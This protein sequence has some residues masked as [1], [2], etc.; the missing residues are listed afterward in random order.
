MLMSNAFALSGDNRRSRYRSGT[1]S[2]MR[3][4]SATLPRGEFAMLHS[5]YWRD[6]NSGLFEM[7]ISPRSAPPEPLAP[8]PVPPVPVNAEL[9]Y[10]PPKTVRQE[11]DRRR[12]SSTGSLRLEGP[13]ITVDSASTLTASAELDSAVHRISP[14]TEAMVPLPPTPQV[15][16]PVLKTQPIEEKQILNSEPG[17]SQDSSTKHESVAYSEAIRSPSLSVS[18]VLDYYSFP[19]SPDLVLGLDRNFRPA[20]SPISEESTS[21]L[22][23]ASPYK[24]DLKRVV[25]SGRLYA[26]SPASPNG[27]VPLVILH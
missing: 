11:S 24:G 9:V 17:P 23:P 12:R 1:S 5:P 22:S 20:F 18:E 21:Q 14:I 27:N 7:P 2:L 3:S 15:P 19:E 8:E 6:R 25:N 10:V 13:S 26:N 4:D 16:P